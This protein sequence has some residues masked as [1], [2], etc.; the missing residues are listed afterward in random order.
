MH[1]LKVDYAAIVASKLSFEEFQG[2]A[3]PLYAILSHRWEDEEVTFSDV[4]NN[5]HGGAR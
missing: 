5:D 2:N 1:L 4:K 3:I